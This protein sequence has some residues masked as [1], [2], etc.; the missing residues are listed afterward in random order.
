MKYPLLILLLLLFAAKTLFSQQDQKFED[1][2]AQICKYFHGDDPMNIKSEIN[3]N[4][5]VFQYDV[6]FYKLD[7]EAYDTTNQFSGYADVKVKV[8]AAQLDTFSMELSHK[9]AIDSVLINGTL[10]SYTHLSD[11]IYIIF[12]TPFLMGDYIDF[13][14]F[15]HTPPD[16][17]SIYYSA[18]VNP[19]YDN[20]P[21]SQTFSEPYFAHE[22]MPVKQVLEDKADSINIFIT[23]HNDLRVA[24]PGLLTEV[25]LPGNKI[26][27]EWRTHIPTAFYLICFAISDYQEYA[28]YAKP[29]SLPNDSILILNYLFDYPNLLETNKTNIDHTAGMIEQLSNQYGLFPFYQE[30]YGHYMWYPTNFSGME[31]ITMSGMRS[32][33][34]SLISHELGHSWFGDNV[35]CAS[36]SDIWINEG[37]ATYTE[38]LIRE[39]FYGKPTADA[40][41]QVYH[42]Y[43]LSSPDGSVYVPAESLTSWGRIFSTRLTYR[44]GGALVHMI[45]YLVN[46]DSLFFRTLYEFQLEY[47]DSVATGADFRDKCMQVSGTDFTDFFDQWYYGEGFP[48]YDLTWWQHA[49]TVFLDVQQ[50]TSTAVTTFFDIPVEYKLHFAGGDSTLR[51][52]QHQN[53]TVYRFIFPEEITDVEIDPENWILNKVNSITHRKLLDLRLFLGGAFDS[54]TGEMTTKLNPGYLTPEQPYDQFPWFYPGTEN[55]ITPKP[56]VVDW[57]L[58]ALYDTTDASLA[59]Q[60]TLIHQQAVLLHRNGSITLEDG[61]S[62]V[63]FDEPVS[64]N[65]YI[66]LVHRNHLS[67]LSSA[68]PTYEKGVYSYDFSTGAGQVLGGAAGYSEIAS[69]IW[70][71]TSGDANADGMINETDKSTVWEPSGG[72][73]GYLNADLNLDGQTDN[74]DKD[75]YWLPYVGQSTQVPD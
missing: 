74:V 28:I 73:S 15:Y 16:Y 66:Q 40:L 9:L 33:G 43:V 5:L 18:S 60:E 21:V 50:S 49:D 58:I 53:D 19:N 59:S 63:Y 67:I 54:L 10:H 68:E 25:P 48:S 37:F 62:T 4:S 39:G 47:A 24:G 38:Y 70:G 52:E 51:L 12:N 36:W 41:M 17:S 6:K 57:M 45:R 34:F 23:T 14:L 71:M 3:P 46:N 1:D 31:H 69:G 35:T 44:K 2:P 61:L 13:T 75:Q 27:Y 65:L 72:L 20:F 30:K 7:L 22:W 42:N 64:N 29:D 32:L 55:F 26:R 11:N 56:D 8:A